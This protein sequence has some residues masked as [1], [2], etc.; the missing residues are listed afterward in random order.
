MRESFARTFDTIGF[1]L[2]VTLAL[3]P[4][5]Y[6]G[7]AILHFFHLPSPAEAAGAAGPSNG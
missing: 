2:G 1:M 4:V 6:I 5:L 7:A 3:V